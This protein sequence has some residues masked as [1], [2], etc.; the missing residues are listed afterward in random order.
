M[1]DCICNFFFF[2][3]FFIVAVVNFPW[4]WKGGATLT[5]PVSNYVDKML[6]C[7]VKNLDPLDLDDSSTGSLRALIM[8]EFAKIRTYLKDPGQDIQKIGSW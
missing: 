1:Q 4:P 7:A 5:N 6:T 3:S 2:L 8:Q